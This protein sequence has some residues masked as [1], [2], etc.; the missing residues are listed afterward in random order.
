MKSIKKKFNPLRGKRIVHLVDSL[1]MIYTRQA[2]TVYAPE[3]NMLYEG[4]EGEV[5]K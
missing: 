1:E 2:C 4:A 5:K 3:Y